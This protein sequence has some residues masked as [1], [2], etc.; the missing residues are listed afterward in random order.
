MAGA[1]SAAVRCDGCLGSTTCWV[2]LGTG[3]SN[4]DRGTGL[5]TRCHGSGRCAMCQDVPGPR[6]SNERAEFGR[7]ASYSSV[8]DLHR[9][10]R[11]RRAR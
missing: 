8:I 10:Q 4:T 1:T 11:W 6:E 7:L 9:A 2:C 3:R 5:C